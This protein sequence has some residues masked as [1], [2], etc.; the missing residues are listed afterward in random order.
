MLGIGPKM[1]EYMARTFILPEHDDWISLESSSYFQNPLY[2]TIAPIYLVETRLK[3]S[4]VFPS[5]NPASHS[6]EFLPFPFYNT[7]PLFV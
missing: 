1:T 2:W 7:L 5:C 4:F 6:V 3:E